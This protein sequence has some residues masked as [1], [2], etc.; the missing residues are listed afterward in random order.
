MRNMGGPTRRRD[1]RPGEPPFRHGTDHCPGGRIP[2]T[3]R[4]LIG[5]TRLLLFGSG[6]GERA[7][8]NVART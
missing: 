6:P 2:F 3:A 8:L 1:G 5:R 4:R 7:A